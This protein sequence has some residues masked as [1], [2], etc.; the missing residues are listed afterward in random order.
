MKVLQN[1]KKLTAF[2]K[3]II[4]F[5][6][7]SGKNT[8][9]SVSKYRFSFFYESFPENCTNSTAV[10]IGHPFFFCQT[11]VHTYLPL[12]CEST[13]VSVSCF[14]SFLKICFLQ[15]HNRYFF[16]SIF[17]KYSSISTR[18]SFLLSLCKCPWKFAEYNEIQ[19]LKISK[20]HFSA[21][22]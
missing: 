6:Q 1:F 17:L 16:A 9:V 4:C 11:I 15:N 19:F 18:V 7:V 14:L 21:Q 3:I 8:Q 2:H 12:Y 13:R 10:H 22:S 5:L 20:N